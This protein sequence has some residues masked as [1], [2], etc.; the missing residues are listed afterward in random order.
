[1]FYYILDKMSYTQ[2]LSIKK[3]DDS[4]SSKH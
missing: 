3:A 4:W 2:W 1:M